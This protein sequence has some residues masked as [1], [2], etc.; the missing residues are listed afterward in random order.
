MSPIDGAYVTSLNPTLTAKNAVRSGPV[1]TIT[2][3]FQ[4]SESSTFASVLVAANVAE[5][6]TQSTYTVTQTLSNSKTYYWRVRASDPATTGPWS[7][8]QWFRTP[9]PVT[10]TPD[11]GT[12]TDPVA[13][14]QITMSAATILNSPR[15]LAS[16]PI[17]SKLS[18]V[19]ISS[20]GIAV[21]FSKK[22]GSGRWPDVTPPG[23]SGALQY[24]LG[25]CL[26]INSQWYCSAV[27]EFWYGLERSGGPPSG[28]AT[29]WFYDPTRWYPMTG[30][31]PAVGETIG[32]FVCAG[33]LPQQP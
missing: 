29:N 33:R 21:Q 28:F 18:V 11:P 2:Y 1:G 10:T 17:T 5:Q 12:T 26:T 31:Q 27:V 7:T 8:Q 25:M 19:D 6:A 14:D 30:H 23:W 24:T 9:D 20:G 32:F 4:V 13:P 22:D 3:T 15:N 16:W